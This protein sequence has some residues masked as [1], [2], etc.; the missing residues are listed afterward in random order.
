MRGLCAYLPQEIFIVDDTLKANIALGE[1]AHDINLDKIS[2]AIDK[3]SLN[4]LVESLEQGI[5]TK[6]GDKG[7]RLSGGQRQRVAIARAFYNEREILV[8]DES[9]SALDTKTEADISDQIDALKGKK[10][11]IIIAH[12]ES[13]LKRC[14]RIIR[15]D[16]GKFEAV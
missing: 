1:A 4:E 16:S 9:T 10:T 13:T 11:L 12:R 2:E 3:S 5:L 15:L 7:V 14:D 6:M 8:L